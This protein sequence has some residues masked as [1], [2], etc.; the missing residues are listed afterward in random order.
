LA[1]VNSVA[2]AADIDVRTPLHVTR[3]FVEAP[4]PLLPYSP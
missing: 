3:P 2:S 1:T 4:D